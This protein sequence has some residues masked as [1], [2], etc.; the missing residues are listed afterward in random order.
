MKGKKNLFLSY[1]C[2]DTINKT[3]YKFRNNISSFGP[4]KCQ[5]YVRLPWIVFPYQVDCR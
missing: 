3:V 2:T 1:V 4:S 5:V